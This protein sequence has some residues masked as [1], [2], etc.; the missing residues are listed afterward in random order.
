M[1]MLKGILATLA[2]TACVCVAQT[3]DYTIRQVRDP[4]QLKDALNADIT[5]I[6]GR[7]DA[8][9][10]SAT[11]LNAAYIKTGNIALAR[12]TNALVTAT[13]V[14]NATTAL[15]GEGSSITN[16]GAANIAL[17]GTFPAVVGT[18]LTALNGENIQ[19]DTIDDDSID[20]ADVTGADLTLTDCGAIAGTT[21]TASGA[22]T[23]SGGLTIISGAYTGVLNIVS[24][25][26]TLVVNGTVTNVLDADIT[27]E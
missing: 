8:F 14:G 27:S 1:K 13:A 20:F 24:T 9:D 16:L 17:G 7:L 22:I 21:I 23:G 5:T 15:D 10:V 2:L 11:N 18:A 4:I 3:A 26:L 25:T 12:V 6:D 19:D